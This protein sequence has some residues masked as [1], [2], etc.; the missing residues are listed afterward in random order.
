MPCLVCALRPA[1]HR[2]STEGGRA[3]ELDW[4]K[5]KAGARVMGWDLVTVSK[6]V[7]RK[8]HRCECGK[9]IEPGE[10]YSRTEGLWEGEWCTLKFHLP[11]IE[12]EKLV[13]NR[14]NLS[15]YNDEGWISLNDF[16]SEDWD[17]LKENHSDVFWACPARPLALIQG[18]A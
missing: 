15:G 13:S 6:P 7:A 16:D 1:R 17:W 14:H 8:Q 3:G 5:A 9:T 11:C 2:S 12:A 10:Q 4:A 18:D